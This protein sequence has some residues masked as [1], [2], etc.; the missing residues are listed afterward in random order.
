[1]LKLNIVSETDIYKFIEKGMRGGTSY[2]TKKNIMKYYDKKQSSKCIV[3]E[4]ANNGC[5][6]EQCLKIFCC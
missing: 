4:S 1:M 2:T 3:N 6:D 5:M